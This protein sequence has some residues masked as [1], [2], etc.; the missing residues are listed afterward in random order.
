MARGSDTG[1]TAWAPEAEQLITALRERHVALAERSLTPGAVLPDERQR[2]IGDL[3]QAGTSVPPGPERDSVR[4]ML[5]FWSTDRT[6]AVERIRSAPSPSLDAYIEPA[7]PEPPSGLAPAMGSAPLPS[8]SPSPSPSPALP[9]SIAPILAPRPD[10]GSMTTQR[11]SSAAAWTSGLAGAAG[12]A[13]AAAT[14]ALARPPPLAPPPAAGTIPDS[15]EAR[16]IVRIAAMAREWRLTS[17]SSK[18][19]YL[20]GDSA[21]LAEAA[22]Y[23]G[24]DPEIAAFVEASQAALAAQ[25]ARNRLIVIVLVTAALLAVASIL[26]LN[27]RRNQVRAETERDAQLTFKVE[28]ARDR[29]RTRDEARTAV[30]GL[31]R[32]DLAPLQ[33]LLRRLGDADS[34]ELAR[35]DLRPEASAPPIPASG[36]GPKPAETLAA[37]PTCSGFLWLGSKDG[38]TRLAGHRA[39]TTLGPGDEA[40]L[41]V[42]GDLRAAPGQPA[43]GTVNRQIGLIPAG[44]PFKLA[45]AAVPLPGQPEQLW[46]QV[47]TS[48]ANCTR[49]FLQYTGDTEQ[50]D[51]ALQALQDLAVQVP[52]AEQIAS[53]KN[54]CE[55]RY[56]WPEDQAAAAQVAS[57]LAG[58][59]RPKPRLVAL[60]AYSNKPAP[61]T[62][63]AW[64]DLTRK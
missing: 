50:L 14:A 21:T 29:E 4:N 9:P 1:M 18:R 62:I 30:D 12:T 47:I 38:T 36:D 51:T 13:I 48:R 45:E 44:N 37:E 42:R 53:A 28:A 6:G 20:I 3:V 61:G 15:A 16:R 27:A 52:P 32:G 43:P 59:D 2:M 10:E 25:A 64:V 31:Q 7:A 26:W 35:L 33:S 19:G 60:T 63:E 56:F 8:P 57:A 39:V 58:T 34:S 40:A 11:R 41:T 46:A 23:A 17:P 54:Q 22:R 5:F 24:S 55:I 49:V